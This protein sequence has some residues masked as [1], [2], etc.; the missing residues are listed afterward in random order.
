MAYKVC[1]FVPGLH[2]QQKDW[3]EKKRAR[4]D[5]RTEKISKSKEAK[6]KVIQEVLNQTMCKDFL[7]GMVSFSR[8]TALG[9]SHH[10][11]MRMPASA[12]L[13]QEGGVQRGQSLR[14]KD[15]KED[16]VRVERT[17]DEPYPS[18]FEGRMPILGP[19]RTIWT[20]RRMRNENLCCFGC[21]MRCIMFK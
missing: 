14:P 4:E 19:L 18:L 2:K 13:P 1:N 11:I 16:Q 15:V 6:T 12:V 3:Y 5:E 21:E 10:L 20:T 9:D 8:A 7:S 17:R